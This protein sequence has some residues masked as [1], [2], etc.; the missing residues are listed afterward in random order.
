MVGGAKPGPASASSGKTVSLSRVATTVPKRKRGDAVFTPTLGR[1][2]TPAVC[3]Y[4]AKAT[5]S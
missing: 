5:L 2:Q 3:R 4:R 1:S